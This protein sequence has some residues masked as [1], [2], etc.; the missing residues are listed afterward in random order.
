MERKKR[1]G[2]HVANEGKMGR[3]EIIPSEKYRWSKTKENG[4]ESEHNYTITLIGENVLAQ[5]SDD[6]LKAYIL[7]MA[8]LNLAVFIE[9]RVCRMVLLNQQIKPG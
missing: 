9:V 2:E 5:R 3:Q 8:G 4:K 7:L 6:D 1:G